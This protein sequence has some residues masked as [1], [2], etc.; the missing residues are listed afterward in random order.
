MPEA[1]IFVGIAMLMFFGFNIVVQLLYT[2]KAVPRSQRV[3]EIRLSANNTLT[4]KEIDRRFPKRPYGEVLQELNSD[5]DHPSRQGHGE[6][7]ITCPICLCT[8][9][10]DDDR[11]MPANQIPMRVLSCKHA[12]HADCVVAWLNKVKANC[13]TCRE[14]F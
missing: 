1:I 11:N 12:F 13:P 5:E 3:L 2:V 9:G 7:N 14:K 8:V 6:E 10:V 4:M